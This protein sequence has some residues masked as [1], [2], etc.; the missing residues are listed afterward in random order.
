MM[1]FGVAVVRGPLEVVPMTRLSV[2]E[3]ST[4]LHVA[5]DV[6]ACTAIEA[7]E[8]VARLEAFTSSWQVEQPAPE[9][10]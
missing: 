1:K 5:A 10:I 3:A 8:K 7:E 4:A 6:M 2:D 9:A